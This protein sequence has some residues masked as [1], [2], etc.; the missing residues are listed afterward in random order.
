MVIIANTLSPEFISTC[1]H[2]I[3]V[4]STSIIRNKNIEETQKGNSFINRARHSNYA[5]VSRRL[6][7]ALIPRAN[8]ATDDFYDVFVSVLQALCLVGMNRVLNKTQINI[9]AEESQSS[10]FLVSEQ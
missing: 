5:P 7:R 10:Y 4:S 2:T 9:S 6:N 8:N 3:A 1:S